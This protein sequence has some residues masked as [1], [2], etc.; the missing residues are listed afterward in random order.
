VTVDN[1]DVPNSPLNRNFKE[2]TYIRAYYNLFPG[3]K[4]AGLD[5][6]NEITKEDFIGGYGIY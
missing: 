6:G 2:N 3:I 1:H 4:R 5:W